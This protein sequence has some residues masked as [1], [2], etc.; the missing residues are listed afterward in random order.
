MGYLIQLSCLHEVGHWLRPLPA[1]PAPGPAPAS[2]RPSISSVGKGKLDDTRVIP[3]KLM[4]N[5]PSK[6]L[7]EYFLRLDT[8]GTKPRLAAEESCKRPTRE[9]PGLFRPVPLHSGLQP[10]TLSTPRLHINM[11][12]VQLPLR[13]ESTGPGPG[14]RAPLSTARV[15]MTACVCGFPSCGHG[16]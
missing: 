2:G 6:S 1:G 7:H 16:E 9:G 5:Q 13:Q 12:A 11:Q 10:W 15:E 4:E 8:F 14:A 3:F